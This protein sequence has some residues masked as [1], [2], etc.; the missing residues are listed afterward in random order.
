MRLHPLSLLTGLFVALRQFASLIVF[1]IVAELVRS[2]TSQRFGFELLWFIFLPLVLS[3]ASALA[4]YVSTTYTVG[5]TEVVLDTGLV[6]KRRR[7][8]PRDRIQEVHLTQSLLQRA[9]GITQVKIESAAGGESE[10]VLDSLGEEEAETLRNTLTGAAGPSIYQRPE[11]PAYEVSTGRIVF[12]S[13]LEN[14]ALLLVAGLVGAAVPFLDDESVLR[15]AAQLLFDQGRSASPA[16]WL[17]VGAAVYLAG[18]AFSGVLGVW[19][20]AGFRIERHPKGFQVVY[21]LGKRTQRVMRADRVQEV[22]LKQGLMYRLA[23]LYEVKA[24]SAGVAVVRDEAQGFGYLSPAATADEVPH[25]CGLAMP[26]LDPL[27]PSAWRRLPGRALPA[28]AIATLMA[29]PFPLAG[30][31]ALA[32]WLGRAPVDE[33]FVRA[34]AP[35]R[36][37]GPA[38]L[39][40][41]VALSVVVTVLRART[42]RHRLLGTTATHRVGGLWRQWHAVP[43][44]RTQLVGVSQ[45]PLQRLF[46]LCTVQVRVAASAVSFRDVDPAFA[47]EARDFAVSARLADPRRGV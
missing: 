33:D 31:A 32:W 21:G 19:T 24:K 43:A 15:R 7:V 40:F 47:A 42:E 25:L 41:L 46:R 17:L 39:A 23:G 20:F 27:A 45:S 10:I 6:W 14:R 44:N 9:L 2:S 34:L 12:A 37:H 16:T 38:V 30:L 22:T 28:R 4:R 1:L 35:A 36:Q 26:G 3:T 29:W 5:P 11:R 18:W 8:V 13:M